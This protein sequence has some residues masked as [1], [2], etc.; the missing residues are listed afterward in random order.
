M[1][2]RQT[3][4]LTELKALDN[5]RI[6]RCY[7]NLGTSFIDIQLHGFSDASEQTFAAVLYLLC[8]SSDG[9]VVTR[10]VASKTRVAPAKKQSI[11]WLELL[12]T[13]ILAKL[14][15]TN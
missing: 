7:F 10:L 14:I 8:V 6:P 2:E 9:N 12:G 4:L 15:N 5:V 11:P 1:L 13:L 3:S